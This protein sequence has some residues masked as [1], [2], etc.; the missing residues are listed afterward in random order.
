MKVNG[1]RV[2]YAFP[3]AGASASVYRP[4]LNPNH[5]GRN[6]LL[7]PIDL[8]GRG[9]LAKEASIQQLD[10][11]VEQLAKNISHDFRQ[12][13]LAGITQWATFGHS[14]G[15]VLSVAVTKQLA[16]HH[17]M[18]PEFSV[19]SGSIA[20]CAQ[21]YDELHNWTDEQI[22]EKVKADMATP[23]AVLNIPAL[24]QRIVAQLRSDY[25]VRSQFVTLNKMQV[26]QPLTLIS[27]SADQH[28]SRENMT[29]WKNHTSSQTSLIEIEG[30]HF[31]VYRHWDVIKQ[32]LLRDSQHMIME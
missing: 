4:W 5:E 3:H 13:K 23:D 17:D 10:N 7:S 30:D 21:E 6:A 31:A 12:K 15:G 16:H 32:E 29:A 27:A 26:D 22:L 14:F 11:L 2:I 25:I 8:P 20:P 18:S 9:S 24:A 28:I 1:N 19:V